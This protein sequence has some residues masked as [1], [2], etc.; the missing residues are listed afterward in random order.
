MKR[1]LFL[2]AILPFSLAVALCACGS[3]PG[4]STP[5]EKRR[6][7]F[8]RHKRIPLQQATK[9]RLATIF[10]LKPVQFFRMALFILWGVKVP[11]AS[12]PM[13]LQMMGTA[14]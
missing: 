2:S 1:N 10:R 13:S 11:M 5:S 4:E 3:T 14:G 6:A 7:P 12:V 9:F 8:H